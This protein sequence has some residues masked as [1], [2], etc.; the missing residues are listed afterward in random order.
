MPNHFHCLVQQR[1][2]GGISQFMQRFLNSYTRYFNTRHGRVGP[3]LAGQFRAVRVVTDEQLLHVS[4]YIHL[5]PY[6][7]GLTPDPFT[8]RWS[9]IRSYGPAE[10][11]SNTVRLETGLIR[12]MISGKEY[13]QF[14]WDHAGYARDLDRIKHLLMENEVV[15]NPNFRSW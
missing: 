14:I 5:N 8:Y 15:T 13:E 10:E 3:L 12:S 2:E 7:A 9:S 1:T 6:V 4:R 11:S